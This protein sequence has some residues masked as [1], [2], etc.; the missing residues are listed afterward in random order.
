MAQE[1]FSFTSKG[2]MFPMF[3]IDRYAKHGCTAERKDETKINIMVSL[4]NTNKI[5]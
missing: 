2:A 1:W 4:T 5:K 3:L